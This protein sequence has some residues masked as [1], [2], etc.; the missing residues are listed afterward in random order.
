MR[1][2]M[3]KIL[4]FFIL[5][6]NVIYAAEVDLDSEKYIIYNMND[7]EIIDEKN[8]HDR[9]S[10]A[11]LTKIMTV[12]VAIEHIDNFDEKVTITSN[13]L[14]G[15]DWDVAVAG[16]KV[17]DKVTYNDLLY[18]A[19]LPSGADA[20]NSLAILVS[21]D[22]DDFVKLMNE[23]VNELGLKDTHFENVVGLYDE[24]NYSSAYDMAQILIYALKNPKFKEVFESKKY[25]YSTGKTTKSTIER[26]NSNNENISYITGSKTGY[27]KKAGYCLAS[28]ATLND[29]NYLLVTLNAYSKES[30][31][32]IKDHIKAYNYFNDNYSYKNIVNYDDIVVTLKTKYSKEKEIGI[33]SNVELV[34][35]LKNDF[36]KSK[37]K[38]EY[39]GMDVISYFTEKGTT[40]GHVKI[41]YEDK[42]LNEFDLVYNQELTFSLLSYLWINKVYVIIII[43]FLLLIMRIISVQIKRKK[44]LRRKRALQ[45]RNF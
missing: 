23:K 17:G 20:V 31:I 37:V 2:I 28:T 3:I 14:K 35:Y 36:D 12:I 44:R 5:F 33:K 7:N 13:M 39:T 32:H 41:K 24:N 42:I 1:N 45:Q 34:D 38:Y 29:V 16:F 30:S 9:T 18:G 10:I 22:K 6:S 15:I 25:T 4:L 27:I 8:S 26:Y 40:L 11:S 21:S 19:I 43:I